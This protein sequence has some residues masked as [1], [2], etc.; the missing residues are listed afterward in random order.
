MELGSVTAGG[1]HRSQRITAGAPPTRTNDHLVAPRLYPDPVRLGTSTF[2]TPDPRGV[3]VAAIAIS[4]AT[5]GYTG[6]TLVGGN[7]FDPG[8]VRRQPY[9]GDY[10]DIVA[11]DR[12]YY[13]EGISPPVGSLYGL[14]SD[15]VLL[16]WTS[17]PRPGESPA[18]PRASRR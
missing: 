9:T 12:S 3:Y 6:Y 5:M 2:S 10:S 8:S 4:G 18:L 16:R 11:L 14:R 15:G 13:R 17:I 7:K 1:D